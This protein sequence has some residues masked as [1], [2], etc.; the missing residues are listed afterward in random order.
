MCYGEGLDWRGTQKRRENYI[1]RVTSVMLY[2]H[3]TWRRRRHD[4]SWKKR[5]TGY[6]NVRVIVVYTWMC[7]RACVC[8]QSDFYFIMFQRFSRW[9]LNNKLLV[10]VFCSII[11]IYCCNFFSF[12]LLLFLILGRMERGRLNQCRIH[13]NPSLLFR[14]EF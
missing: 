5:R 3:T 11:I 8:I 1:Y 2:T 13:F 14:F 7:A 12:F 9:I 4:L 6:K 10:I